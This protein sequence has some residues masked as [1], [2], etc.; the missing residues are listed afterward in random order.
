MFRERISTLIDW[1]DGVTARSARAHKNA[2]LI[3]DCYVVYL[4]IVNGLVF[5]PKRGARSRRSLLIR[6]FAGH[7]HCGC[8][9]CR[10][11]YKWRSARRTFSVQ[12]TQTQHK[13]SFMSPI[14]EIISYIV[15]LFVCF[16]PDACGVIACG[17]AH[18]R[19]HRHH[20]YYIHAS[21]HVHGLYSG[22]Y[23]ICYVYFGRC[24]L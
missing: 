4:C 12:L 13:M 3:F 10:S 5:N 19:E 21:L 7:F 15:C 8:R 18:I 22:L 9:V 17:H 11:L 2:S 1:D 6:F 20:V 24:V 16:G 23:R 14:C